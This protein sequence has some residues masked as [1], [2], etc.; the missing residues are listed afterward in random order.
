MKGLCKDVKLS[1]VYFEAIVCKNIT[2]QYA[3]SATKIL[4]TVMT[5]VDQLSKSSLSPEQRYCISIQMFI[6]PEQKLCLF[7]HLLANSSQSNSMLP[8]S[9]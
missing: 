4:E 9:F 2:E 8:T 1:L 6:I 7:F 5:I 3:G